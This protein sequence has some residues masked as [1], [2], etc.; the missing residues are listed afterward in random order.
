MANREDEIDFNNFLLD[1][2]GLLSNDA[3]AHQT[4]GA[5][6]DAGFDAGCTGYIK[7]NHSPLVPYSTPYDEI[8]PQSS[9]SSRNSFDS[10]LAPFTE[11]PASR[12]SSLT[13][14]DMMADTEVQVSKPDWNQNPFQFVDAGSPMF[15]TI[16]PST[17]ENQ[18]NAHMDHDS[19][20][21][22]T[23]MFAPVGDESS[24]PVMDKE[25]PN[26]DTFSFGGNNFQVSL[27]LSL[28]LVNLRIPANRTIK[29]YIPSQPMETLAA[30]NHR[31][32][33]SPFGQ[34]K[35]SPTY[36]FSQ[37]HGLP[38]I[39]EPT[40][41]AGANLWPQPPGSG[42]D[43]RLFHGG[44][45]P[46]LSDRPQLAI[47]MSVASK[48]YGPGPYKL[49]IA[50]DPSKRK[51]RV[52]TQIH[53]RIILSP[54]PAG[55]TRIHLPHVNICKPKFW[56]KPPAKP[57]PDTLELHVSVVC[58]SAMQN[59]ELLKAALA[60][61]RQSAQTGVPIP[62]VPELDSAE[63]A[64]VGGK[65]GEVRICGNCVCRESKRAQRRKKV[66]S[67][68]EDALFMK[69]EW[70]RV[71]LFNANEYGDWIKPN[72][73]DVENGLTACYFRVPMRITC[74][75]RHHNE[76][77]GF[78]VIF[79]LTNYLGEFVAQR[80][81][82]TVMITDDHKTNTTSP[83]SPAEE[84]VNTEVQDMNGLGKAQSQSPFNGSNASLVDL[85]PQPQKSAPTPAHTHRNLSRSA[86]PLGDAGPSSKRRKP[87]SHKIPSNLQMTPVGDLSPQSA[88]Q[89]RMP[90]LDM[91]VVT[92]SGFPPSAMQFSPSGYQPQLNFGRQVP[93]P[94][95]NSPS[96]TPVHGNAFSGLMSGTTGLENLAMPMYSAPA[97]THASRAPSPSGLRTSASP[98]PHPHSI[99]S[100][101]MHHGALY[102][103]VPIRAIQPTADPA[104]IHKVIPGD[105]PKSGG[106]EVT[107]LG[108]G[109]TPGVSIMFGDTEATITTLWGQGC[110]VCLLPPS[111]TTGT[112]PVTVKG[113][114]PN[115]QQPPAT[116]TYNNEDEAKL[117]RLALRILNSGNEERVSQITQGII[118]YAATYGSQAGNMSGGPMFTGGNHTMNMTNFE[119]EILNVFRL[120]DLNG[121]PRGYYRY[122]DLQT[123][124]GHSMLH[125]AASLGLPRVVDG[126]LAR[127]V[128][129]DLR[130][131][132]GY[133]PLHI[134]ALNNHVDIV[135]RL[136]AG[137]A[138]PALRTVSGLTPREVTR[139]K[140]VLD[141]I[142]T[143]PRASLPSSDLLHRRVR[144][145]TSLRR[146][147]NPLPQP[148]FVQGLP[149][150]SQSE[151]GSWD[152]SSSDES[153]GNE[154]SDD[155]QAGVE[156][157]GLSRY[158][159]EA[160]SSE[161]RQPE[162]P[163]QADNDVPERPPS[164]TATVAALK[165]QFA[166]QFQHLQQ[167]M[168]L[169]FQSLPQFPFQSLPQFPNM[170]APLT[171]YQ[172]RLLAMVPT[173]GYGPRPDSPAGKATGKWWELGFMGTQFKGSESSAPP[174]Y[175]ELYPQGSSS[176]D[177]KQ[178]TAAAAAAEAEADQKCA[179]LYD[180]V[181]TT[182][183]ATD[184][185]KTE[186]LDGSLSLTSDEEGESSATGGYGGFLPEVLQ[187]PR[188]SA[189]T[190]EHRDTLRQ[191]H[192]IKVSRLSS[193]WKLWCIWMPA[194]VLIMAFMLYNSAF[195]SSGRGCGCG[196]GEVKMVQHPVDA[197][198][199]VG[200]FMQ[201]AMQEAVGG[202]IGGREANLGAAGLA[203]GA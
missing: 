83:D 75:C 18:A 78:Q 88:T 95:G 70:E 17:I 186:S 37:S 15:L 203:Q 60:R 84:V 90:A 202:D 32:P 2:A 195:F 125:L 114:A 51:S 46:G 160:R 194:L 118:E 192:A 96:H 131:K 94:F 80:L 193:D 6:F 136:L 5:G 139:S 177:T 141:I 171:D 175:E 97:S 38:Q 197:A 168:A 159:R 71:L 135:Q 56:A 62:F 180:T 123:Q 87:S 55:I 57:S 43:M 165:E 4:R 200:K 110:T 183:N 113:Q 54:L 138:D 25:S 33:S 49:D 7:T 169:N 153:E 42:N 58:T 149:S 77:S 9:G 67:K 31:S 157:K 163:A 172:Q 201:D 48:L 13:E 137:G 47:P 191:A 161:N 65:G 144:S 140:E 167:M 79:T 22:G 19:P 64:K 120:I 176:T 11:S 189:I 184:E 41:G 98:M 142:P 100:A 20:L 40:A 99:Q 66:K 188:R 133:T 76:K 196:W 93:L 106:I 34:Q 181:H 102:N 86:S 36:D 26:N 132:G 28:A 119:S 63:Q 178:A 143:Q 39:P 190:K 74:Y 16:D 173:L 14:G 108:A 109:F 121:N 72:K 182:N 44:I 59:P 61:A 91:S 107:V 82:D 24:P 174:A 85:Q 30:Q 8:S 69:D 105:G 129:T 111:P 68:E 152:D 126:L 27:H 104:V 29:N 187:I 147:W 117:M 148:V 50:V 73:D 156:M 179:A 92:P 185:T 35:L 45:S 112:V 1:E 198:R 155:E 101:A 81:S 128:N 158:V 23:N 21:D 151:Y 150:D 145:A 154:L 52:E 10:S 116:F 3:D 103:G 53:I 124:S 115:P 146:A 162:K 164:P 127:E 130:D 170:P 122:L 12:K 89:S 199:A 134:A 166:A